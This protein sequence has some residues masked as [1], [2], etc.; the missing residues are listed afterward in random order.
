MLPV[1]LNVYDSGAAGGDGYLTQTTKK[2]DGT[3]VTSAND[4]VTNF[5]NDYRGNRTLTSGPLNYCQQVT[6]DNMNRAVLADRYNNSVSTANLLGRNQTLYDNLG[7]VFQTIVYGV[8]VGSGLDG[9]SLTSNLWYDPAGNTIKD[10]PAGSSA[11]TKLV[12]D[13][14]SRQVFSYRGYTDG[15][16][17]YSEAGSVATSIVLE[18]AQT[19][20]DE[21]SN[22]VQTDAYRRFH[23]AATSGSSAQGALEGPSDPN[24]PARISFVVMYPD[25]IART[26]NTADY[27]TN[28]DASSLSPLPNCPARSP[29]VLVTTVVF[30]NRGEPYQTID[31]AGTTNQTTLD[32][33]AR[34][35]QLI[36][37][38][39]SGT[40]ADQNI[41]VNWTY[42]NGGHVS[43]LHAIN[44]ATG[45][46][47][48]SY[49]YGVTVAG[50]SAINSNDVL[51]VTTMPDGG[52][53]VRQVNTQGELLQLTDANG[54]V[55]QFSRDLLGRLTLDAVV[56]IPDSVDQAVLAIGLSY[57]VRSL[58]QKI[59]SYAAASG[60]GST[61]VNEIDNVYDDFWQ[62]QQQYQE[63]SGAVNTSTLSVQYGYADGSANTIRPRWV[64]YP[65]G[66]AVNFGYGTSGGMDDF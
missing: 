44:A 18:Q 9:R 10:Q 30:N 23:T 22:V 19:D 12:Y 56:T 65:H 61:V 34:R 1:V 58:V 29:T 6:Y 55:H 63:H 28:G 60:P 62:L 11:W 41:T 3:R 21:A 15:T 50:G 8:T 45:E 13:A 14:V 27:G 54:T 24:R 20:F 42:D 35:T 33:A 16:V 39:V 31:P 59:T 7:R 66:N 48:T 47:I 32:N 49:S 2:V 46:Q 40:A 57:E 5:S 64:T 53:S 17:N 4:R 37:N 26:V 51:G 36:Q 43:G 25:G 52:T 38:L